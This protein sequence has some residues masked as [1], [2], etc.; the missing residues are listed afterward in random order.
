MAGALLT[1]NEM[2][3][4]DHTPQAYG[5][6]ESSDRPEQ[7]SVALAEHPMSNI[8]RSFHD[9]KQ[10]EEKRSGEG[11]YFSEQWKRALEVDPE[12][13][14]ITGW[15]EWVAMRFNDGS[16]GSFLGKKIKKGETYFVDQYDAEYSR[17]AEPVKGNFQ[18]NYYYQ[19]INGIRKFKGVDAVNKYSGQVKISIDGKFNDWQKAAAVFNDDKGD[20]LHRKHPGW[21]RIKEYVNTTGRN[22]LTLLKVAVDKQNISFYAEAASLL[23]PQSDSNWMVLYVGAHNPAFPQWQGFSH[24][25]N[26]IRKGGKSIVEAYT[27]NNQW[28]ATGTIDMRVS[29]RQLELKVPKEILGIKGDSITIDFKWSDNVPADG[30]PLHWLDKGDAAPN[31]RFAYRFIHK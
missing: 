17:D 7:I 18:D 25:I 30:D 31:A 10:P 26:Q 15:N 28:K 8:G 1:I 16:S 19:M 13:V 3:G 11:L 24:R 5:W 23:T 12:F 21:G 2:D 20:I 6:H 29:G 22:D 14:F 27:G 4:V 9:G